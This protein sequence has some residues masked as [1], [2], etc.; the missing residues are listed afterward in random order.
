[1]CYPA[2]MKILAL[3]LITLCFILV[4]SACQRSTHPAIV[5]PADP[6]PSS[7]EKLLLGTLP[8]PAYG[9][10]F[11][12][13]YRQIAGYASFVPV[14][15]KPSPFYEMAGDLSGDWGKVFV[16]EY[17]RSNN[18]FPIIHLSFIGTGM[19]LA[20]PP[21]IAAPFLDS[22]AWRQAY[23][24]AALDVTRTSRP[25]YLSLGNE[26]NRWYEKYGIADGNHNGFQHYVSLYEEIYDAVKALSPHTIVF[27]TFAREI[28]S[29]NRE[30]DLTALQ[31][32]N[33]DKLDI[34]VLTSYPHAVREINRPSDIPDD[35]YS[36]LINYLP[37]KNL[38]FSEVAWPSLGTFGGET[39]QAEFLRTLCGHLTR[40]QGVKL[41]LLG[42]PWLHD[43]DNNDF[44]GLIRRDGTPKLAYSVWKEISP[45]G[46]GTTG[47]K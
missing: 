31:L 32:F 7:P 20:S 25:L 17:I 28:V 44:T 18:M 2:V 22:P 40:D 21:G 8:V 43:I 36:R 41:R 38:G 24:K 47:N 12:A 42:W 37:D 34:L 29:E 1:M 6:I 10:S 5:T 35:Y 27:C 4:S 11:A 19:T 13:A 14:W 45:T 9:Q 15:G 33:R 23:K 26:V 3:S 39:A 46:D 30:A 16:A